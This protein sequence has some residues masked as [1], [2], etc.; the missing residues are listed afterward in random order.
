[1]DLDRECRERHRAAFR[2]AANAHDRAEAVE[3]MGAVFFAKLGNEPAAERHRAA[4]LKQHGWAEDAR[5][6]AALDA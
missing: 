6:R 1:V 2:R 3:A 4:A 5:A